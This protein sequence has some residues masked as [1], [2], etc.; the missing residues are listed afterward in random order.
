[1]DLKRTFT[2]IG[3]VAGTVVAFYANPAQAYT[4]SDKHCDSGKRYKFPASGL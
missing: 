4:F 1:M 2:C 3:L